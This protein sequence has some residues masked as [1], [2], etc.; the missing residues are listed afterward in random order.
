M[1]YTVDNFTPAGRLI[2]LHKKR[3][4]IDMKNQI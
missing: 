4:E 2:D 3:K 1:T